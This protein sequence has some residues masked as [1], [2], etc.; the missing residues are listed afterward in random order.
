MK[1]LTAVLKFTLQV[2]FAALEGGAKT[3]D[4]SDSRPHDMVMDKNGDMKFRS[5]NV[6]YY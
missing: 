3:N 1:I 5:E 2:A 4:K 6:E